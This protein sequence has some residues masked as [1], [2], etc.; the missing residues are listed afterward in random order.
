MLEDFISSYKKMREFYDNIDPNKAK[1]DFHSKVKL[2]RATAIY[3]YGNFD[4]QV[5]ADI[6]WFVFSL[7]HPIR[8]YK[9]LKD[10]EKYT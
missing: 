9:W 3:D 7:R 10:Q 2:Q 5:G 8:R 1:I 4:E 6:A